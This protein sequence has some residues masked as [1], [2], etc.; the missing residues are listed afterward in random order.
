LKEKPTK[1]VVQV[2]PNAGQNKVIGYE[3]GV[4][5]CRI[6]ALPVKGKAN[7]EL[8]EFLSAILETRKSILSIEKGITRR[9]KVIAIEGLTQEQVIGQLKKLIM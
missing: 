4:W 8:L 9:R 6:A 7:Q 3:D 5:H 2:Q 1:I